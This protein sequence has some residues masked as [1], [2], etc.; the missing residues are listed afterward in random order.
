MHLSVFFPRV[1]TVLIRRPKI[2]A[3]IGLVQGIFDTN[4]WPHWLVHNNF[5]NFPMSQF[6]IFLNINESAINKTK[7]INKT[8]FIG[9]CEM[10][11]FSSQLV[12]RKD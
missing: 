4:L 6:F 7:A 12:K 9:K 10:I 1:W 5:S 2:T 11:V 3:Y 8:L